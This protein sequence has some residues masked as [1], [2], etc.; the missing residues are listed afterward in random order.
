M[1]N[2]PVPARGLRVVRRA[3]RAASVPNAPPVVRDIEVLSQ[4]WK[5]AEVVDRPVLRQEESEGFWC[6]VESVNA[7]LFISS[8]DGE[9]QP[10]TWHT[11]CGFV[12]VSCVC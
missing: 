8:D 10:R 6:P 12:P 4:I 9:A 2:N 11:C 7:Q 3:A 1:L 5:F